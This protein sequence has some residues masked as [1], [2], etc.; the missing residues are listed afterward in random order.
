MEGQIFGWLPS[1]RSRRVTILETCHQRKKAACPSSQL[2]GRRER[3]DGV[4]TVPIPK[5][6][7]VPA[8][9]GIHVAKKLNEMAGRA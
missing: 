3:E 4:E 9:T 2:K 5:R 6:D 8:G 1:G 7:D